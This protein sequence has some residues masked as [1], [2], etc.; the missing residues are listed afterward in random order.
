MAQSSREKRVSDHSSVEPSFGFLELV[1]HDLFVLPLCRGFKTKPVSLG[2]AR[3]H[4]VLLCGGLL[5]PPWVSTPNH[6]VRF[7]KSG[8]RDVPLDKSGPASDSGSNSTW[9]SLEDK[10]FK[11]APVARHCGPNVSLPMATCGGQGR[12]ANTVIHT[13]YL[14]EA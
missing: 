3:H 1:R 6:S 14:E 7:R 8:G 5:E 4:K 10:S 11:C 13:H 2:L 12:F 9:A